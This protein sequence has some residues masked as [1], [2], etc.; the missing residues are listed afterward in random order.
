[1]AQKAVSASAAAEVEAP[2]LLVMSSC[3]QLPFM[4]SQI[5]SENRTDVVNPIGGQR[6]TLR[7]SA[8]RVRIPKNPTRCVCEDNQR[9]QFARI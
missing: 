5:P 1:M 4:V 6:T 9:S 8:Y 7:S 3:D 2:S